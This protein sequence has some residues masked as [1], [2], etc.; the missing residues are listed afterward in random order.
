MILQSQSWAYIQRKPLLEK[1]HAP[2]CSA[3]LLTIAKTWKQTGCLLIAE[4]IKMWHVY[5]IQWNYS[6]IKKN[7]LLLFAATWVDL[8]I[9]ILSKS[10]K[11]KY[12]MMLLLC[13]I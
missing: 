10:H 11:D 3:A 4:W 2:Q 1:I 12:H 6:T 5:I 13:G 9:I 8:E 7:E